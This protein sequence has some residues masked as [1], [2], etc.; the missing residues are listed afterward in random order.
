MPSTL[1][2]APNFSSGSGSGAVAL[3]ERTIAMDLIMQ[4][5]VA[6]FD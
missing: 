3:N 2:S 5:T 4:E 6:R 1:Q